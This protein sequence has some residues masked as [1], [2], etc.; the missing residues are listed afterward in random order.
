M[1]TALGVLST[2]LFS[3][4]IVPLVWEA[5]KTRKCPINKLTL[6]V[7]LAAEASLAI[8]AYQDK[9]IVASC[10][11]NLAMLLSLCYYDLKAYLT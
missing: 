9:I 10:I 8:Y 5:Y 4:L 3:A 1:L 7:W 6:A 2:I 11:I